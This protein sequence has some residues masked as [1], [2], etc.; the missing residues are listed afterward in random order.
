MHNKSEINYLISQLRI[1]RL[2]KIHHHKPLKR[3]NKT[4]H[5]QTNPTH[6]KTKYKVNSLN[7]INRHKT[8]HFKCQH[9]IS[10]KIQKMHILCNLLIRI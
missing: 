2:H 3:I 7:Q 5:Q 6:N 8:N 9:Q 1:G 10:P 4:K